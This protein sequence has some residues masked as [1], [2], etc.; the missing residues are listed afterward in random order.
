MATKVNSKPFQTSEIVLLRKLLM[1]SQANS[2]SCQTSNMELFQ[3][4]VKN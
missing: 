4:I 2:E 1:A 3:K